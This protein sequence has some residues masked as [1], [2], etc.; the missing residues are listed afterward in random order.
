M[1]KE[2]IKTTDWLTRGMTQEQ[3][4]KE[5]QEAIMAAD[6]ELCM[7][8]DLWMERETDETTVDY[9]YVAEKMYDIGY[10]KQVEGEWL[11]INQAKGY[12]EPPYGDTC[13]CSVCEFE[14]D[15]SESNWDFCPHCGAKMINR[16]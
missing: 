11:W 10:R 4:A 3:I 6:L 2:N 15:V 12:L 16:R 1:D 9:D 8:F 5:K 14:I 13:K 7:S